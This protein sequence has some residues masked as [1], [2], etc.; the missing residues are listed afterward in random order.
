MHFTAFP[1]LLSAFP[2]AFAQYG[3]D[4]SSTTTSVASAPVTKTTSASSSV[5][6]VQVG[7]GG[8]T[9]SP[10]NI[11]AAVGE[12][13]EF[14][15]FAPEHSVAQST[16]ASP[17]T[18][19]SNSSFFSGAISTSSGQNT[20]VFTITV[21]DTNAIWFYCA[22]PTHCKL[23]MAGVINAPSDGSKTLA[24]Y[25]AAAANVA[26]SVAPATVQG[27]VLGPA[28]AVSQGTGSSTSSSA[29]SSSTSKNA[30]V[31]TRGRV[32][33]FVLVITGVVAVGVSSLIA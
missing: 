2:L 19:S 11:T 22:V 21:N 31:E 3:D 16:F 14:H 6:T 5:H 10:S 32:E 12:K 33:W 15:F 29:S 24:M 26:N 25:Q 27:G 8:L 1:L 9:Y 7:D 13:V 20:N 28:A 4:G 17:C 18:P 23:G 30:G